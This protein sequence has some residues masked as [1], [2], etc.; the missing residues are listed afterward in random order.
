M[1]AYDESEK[2]NYQYIVFEI[3]EGLAGISPNV[4][5]NAKIR[6]T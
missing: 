4:G 1:V 5:R 3:D 2:N 6:P